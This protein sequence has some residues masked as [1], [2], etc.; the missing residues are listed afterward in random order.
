[1]L[2]QG[3]RSNTCLFCATTLAQPVAQADGFAAA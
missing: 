1:V 3:W 2:G